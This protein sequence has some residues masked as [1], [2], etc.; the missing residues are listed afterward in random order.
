[1]E[2]DVL[3]EEKS[4]ELK[5]LQGKKIQA[6]NDEIGIKESQLNELRAQ[7]NEL[8]DSFQYNLEL[9]AERD[10]ELGNYDTI[11]T[12]L[13]E[14]S[15]CLT[16]ELSDVKVQLADARQKLLEDNAKKEEIQRLFQNKI[17]DIEDDIQRQYDSKEHKLSMEL[18]DTARLKQQLEVKLNDLQEDSER[19]RREWER[20]FEEEINSLIREHS[21]KISDNDTQLFQCQSKLK[22]VSSEREALRLRVSE[23]EESITTQSQHITKMEEAVEHAEW[24]VNNYIS[25]QQARISELEIV[26]SKQAEQ[27]EDKTRI[28]ANKLSVCESRVSEKDDAL[29]RL[30]EQHE[31]ERKERE[32]ETQVLSYNLEQLKLRNKCD[33]ARLEDRLTEANENVSQ[34]Q[35]QLETQQVTLETERHKC[36]KHEV[37]LKLSEGQCEERIREVRTELEMKKQDIARYKTELAVSVKREEA[38][39]SESDQDVRLMKF[40]CEKAERKAYSSQEDLVKDLTSSRDVALA[41]VKRLKSD[42]LLFEDEIKV[43][44]GQI[45]RRENEDTSELTEEDT[46][47]SALRDQNTRLKDVIKQMSADIENIAAQNKTQ[48]IQSTVDEPAAIEVAP[49]ERPKSFQEEKEHETLREEVMFLRKTIISIKNSELSQNNY[50]GELL[51]CRS[52]LQ[53][54]EKE[55]NR[56]LELS[57]SLRS[58]LNNLQDDGKKGVPLQEITSRLQSARSALTSSIER[59]K[60]TRTKS[61]QSQMS[62]LHMSGDTSLNEELS[63][64]CR[65]VESEENRPLSVASSDVMVTGKQMSPATRPTIPTPK[66]VMRGASRRNAGPTSG[67]KKSNIRNYSLKT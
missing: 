61:A 25:A 58:Q 40:R 14:K 16:A 26:L 35:S 10:K 9:L 30:K 18:A 36:A 34:L 60:R 62:L 41:D 50:E 37:N 57:N 52:R 56:L 4:K 8:K 5:N 51:E 64:I 45:R 11:I 17:K 31:S 24:D 39:R 15:D 23:Q 66:L 63:D 1:M 19:K 67:T 32:S 46:E 49:Q 28:M 44:K 12:Q 27:F 20:N 47:I 13:N 3:L 59:E 43:L 6:L 33:M 7:Y 53:Q 2:L 21:N 22:Q 65:M 54:V 55:R 29:K 42:L 48:E 38:F